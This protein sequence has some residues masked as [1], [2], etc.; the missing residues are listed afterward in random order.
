MRAV[1]P[2]PECVVDLTPFPKCVSARPD[3]ALPALGTLERSGNAI[4][5]LDDAPRV[6]IRFIDRMRQ[7]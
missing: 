7:Q 5:Q 6:E 1:I 2:R 3:T 4:G